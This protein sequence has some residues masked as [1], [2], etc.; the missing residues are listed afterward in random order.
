LYPI[1]LWDDMPYK[2]ITVS[3]HWRRRPRKRTIA[4]KAAA[5]QRRPRRKKKVG[6]RQY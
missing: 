3:E 6:P 2:T 5:G 4:E 1:R